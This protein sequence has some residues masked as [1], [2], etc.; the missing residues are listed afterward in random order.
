MTAS[1]PLPK[2]A[3]TLPD[4]TPPLLTEAEWAAVYAERAKSATPK[5]TALGCYFAG[6][7]CMQFAEFKTVING[8][9]YATCWK[10]QLERAV[11]LKTPGRMA[12]RE[13]FVTLEWLLPEEIDEL[14]QAALKA[15]A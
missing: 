5:N 3:G 13:K 12:G 11:A 2:D 14:I 10:C 7:D 6:E 1:K 9:V 4:N 8:S 15:G